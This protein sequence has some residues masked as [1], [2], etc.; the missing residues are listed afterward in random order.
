MKPTIPSYVR[1]LF[2]DVRKETVEIDRHAQFIIRRVLDYGDARSLNWLRRT[3]SD[4]EL[5]EVVKTERGLAH[6]T[7]V[8]WKTYF[9]LEPETKNV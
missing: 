5:K 1:R 7:V 6:K 8:F 2:W 9:G 3:Y 4:D